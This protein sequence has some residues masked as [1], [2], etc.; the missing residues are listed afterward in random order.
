MTLTP[1]PF[2]AIYELTRE[3]TT[4]AWLCEAD[5]TKLKT[6]GWTVK[7]RAPCSQAC[8]RCPAVP[9]PFL[10]PDGS[11]DAIPTTDGVWRGPGPDY[12]RPARLKPWPKPKGWKP[13]LPV[14]AK[15]AA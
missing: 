5:V 12:R 13:K 11:V 15:K 4:Y 6:E 8:D 3:W 7:Y 9:S 10:K 2:V 1:G 14:A